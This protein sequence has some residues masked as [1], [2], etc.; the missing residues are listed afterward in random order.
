M[1]SFCRSYREEKKQNLINY[2]QNFARLTGDDLDLVLCREPQFIM[3]VRVKG[4]PRRTTGLVG[5]LRAVIFSPETMAIITGSPG[6]RRRF[7]DILI[8][9]TD[10]E[11]LRT[12]VDY[13]KIRRQRNRLLRLIKQ[14]S[15]AVSELNYWD[16]ELIRLGVFIGQRRQSAV[17]NLNLFISDHYAVIANSDNVMLKLN[18]DRRSND[19]V[20]DLPLS[21]GRD[22]ADE[23]T[24]LGPHT[25]NLIFLLD[26]RDM[27]NFASRGEIKSAILA[28]KVAELKFLE[29]VSRGGG[30]GA[31]PLLLL[32]DVFSEFD[33][34]RREH[35]LSLI[36]DHQT[37]ITAA[38][39]GLLPEKILKKAKI[40]EL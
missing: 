4:V 28:L 6:D 21:R 14:K 38:D 17:D 9:Q 31:E 40:I 36:S 30:E 25:D 3:K 33:A 37:I 11:Y 12:L 5:I 34:Q 7:F 8:S 13:T 2:H 23:R 10:Y 35:L 27:A 16:G 22:I 24:N 19:L 39:R 20:R 1:L 15:A 29:G 18:Y 32:D 26:N